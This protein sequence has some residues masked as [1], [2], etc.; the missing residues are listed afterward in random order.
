[1][2]SAVPEDST[3][4]TRIAIKVAL[5]Q[6]SQPEVPQQLVT[7]AAM[8]ARVGSHARQSVCHLYHQLLDADAIIT[9]ADGRQQPVFIA[10][11]LVQCDFHELHRAGALSVAA[12]FEAFLLSLQALGG[13]HA[14]LVL[15]RDIKLNNIGFIVDNNTRSISSSAHSGPGGVSARIIDFGEA[16]YLH[17][18]ARGPTD[19]GRCRSPYASLRRHEGHE[20]GFHDDLEMLLYAFLDVILPGGLPWKA[21][22]DRKPRLPKDKELKEMAEMK[23]RF[24]LGHVPASSA[25]K[26]LLEMLGVLWSEGAFSD[27]NHVQR[28]LE[29]KIRRAWGSESREHPA[30]ASKPRRL[31]DCIRQMMSIY[32]QRPQ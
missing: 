12:T 17:T 3:Q 2:Y 11:E 1:V 20:Q 7:E 21:L 10:M 32:P 8:I 25:E 30:T 26:V 27:D 16:V 13:V 5:D 14:S 19:F 29:E 22:P 6:G 18:G 24:R 4:S 23:K 15:H 9:M 28:E 31:M